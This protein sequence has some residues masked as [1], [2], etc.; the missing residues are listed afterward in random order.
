MIP[1]ME[2]R[3]NR[4]GVWLAFAVLLGAAMRIWQYVANPSIW[5][6]EA[7]LARIVLERGPLELF[8]RLD[9][10]MAPPGFLLAVNASVALLGT[11]EYALRLFPLLAGLAGP[12]L[13]YFVA[14]ELLRPVGTIVA[15]LMFALATPLVFFSANL[16]Q[17]SS[18][19]AITLLV[20]IVTL[21]LLRTSLT[22]GSAL[23]AAII[24]APLLFFS[25]AAV[26]SLAA[27][28][29]VVLVEAFVSRRDDRWHRVV[30]VAIW[31][32]SCAGAM[33]YSSSMMTAPDIAYM[34][35]FWSHTFLP[36]H[37]ALPWLWATSTQWFAGL[38]G[39]WTFDGSLHYAWPSLFVVLTLIGGLALCVRTPARGALVLGPIVLALA[40]SAVRAIPFGTRVTLFL[41]PLLLLAVVAGAEW[42][43]RVV[44]RIRLAELV[45]VLLLPLVFWTAWQQRP[46]RMPEHFRPVMQSIADHERPGDAVW[47][48]YSG[49]GA[50]E[51][52]AQRIPI[53]S[54]VTR[55]D[56]NRSDPRAYLRQVDVVRG[57]SRVW[58]V[59]AHASGPYIFDERGLILRY[60]DSIGRRLDEH[61][62]AGDTTRNRAAAYLYDLS[63]PARLAFITAEQFPIDSSAYPPQE[64]SCY[65][66]MSPFGVSDRVIRAVLDAAPR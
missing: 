64:W 61:V 31:A 62:P 1:A 41:L 42:I 45:P 50:F 18:D 16:K 39:P 17:Y 60:L 23:A 35:R 34:Q 66:T 43:G 13:F 21:R 14:R 29:A 59:M 49:G 38:P 40:A 9:G 7:A 37:G 65:A 52:Y 27:A 6:D 53:G 57:R 55:G 8:G 26:L 12:V 54:E 24:A 36:R 4:E 51:Y 32:V 3:S 48:Y 5:V 11:S 15:T 20:M 58:I 56:C 2:E 47:V 46:P 33:A 28:G 25:Q 63:D 10:Q 30:I 19:V 22:R 44:Q